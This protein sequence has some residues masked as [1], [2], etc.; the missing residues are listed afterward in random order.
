MGDFF[1]F[2]FFCYFYI[3]TSTGYTL[4]PSPFVWSYDLYMN[5]ASF[6]YN[7]LCDTITKKLSAILKPFKAVSLQ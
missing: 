4:E 1:F 5:N 2:F 3:K 7:S 6:V